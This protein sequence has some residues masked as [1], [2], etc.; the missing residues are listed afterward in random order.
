MAT[1]QI[2]SSGNTII[3]EQDFMDAIHPN[4]YTLIPEVVVPVARAPITKREFL[5]LF[6]PDEYGA[7]KSAANANSTVDYYWQQFILAEF[8]SLSDP[9]TLAGL[10]MLE[11][12]GLLV[13]GRAAEIVA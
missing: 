10:Q 6:A 3:A 4:D 5:K 12:A 1:Y 11:A 13:S 8:I 2:I 7:I 9:D